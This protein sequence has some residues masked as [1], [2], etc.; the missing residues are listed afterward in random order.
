MAGLVSI[1]CTT[2][3]EEKLIEKTLNSFLAQKLDNMSSEI[4]V[5]DGMS[6]DRTREIVK[7][8]ERKYSNIRLI[9]NPERKNPFGRN[10]GIEEAKGEYIAMLGAHT[11]YADEYVKICIEEMARTDSIGVSGKV[12]TSTDSLNENSLN[13]S[14][15]EA[16]LCGLILTS[17]FG[18]SGSSFRTVKEGYTSMVNF[19]VFKKEVFKIVGLY[20]TSLHRNQDNDFNQRV[21]KNNYKLYNTWKTQCFY[22]PSNTFKGIF[23]YAYNNGFWN[24]KSLKQNSESMK[25]HHYVPFIFVATLIIMGLFSVAGLMINS[26]LQ[27]ALFIFV[28]AL[29]L[30]TGLFF[31]LTIEKYRT[32]KNILS[33]PFLFF[34]FHFTYGWGTL[35]GF[36]SK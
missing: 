14:S 7:S 10:K 22:Y 21:I 5:V 19:P 6:E 30:L 27:T 32:V 18:V 35:R 23:S 36:F 34:A 12:I 20:N 33:L 11:V 31:S 26:L 1:I 25:I 16:Q 3:N 2:Y 13:E 29:H 24:A 9:D 28:I 8:F 4:L 17:K 15:N